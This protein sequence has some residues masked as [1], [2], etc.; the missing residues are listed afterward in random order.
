MDYI[1]E[2]NEIKD[3][4]RLLNVAYEMKEEGYR[5]VQICC[6]TLKESYVLNYS[7]GKEYD[8]LNYK[9]TINIDDEV[10][11]LSS[12]FK[13]AFLYENEMKDLFG[14]KIKHIDVDYK[15]HL[16]DLE[17][18]TPYKIDVSSGKVDEE[19]HE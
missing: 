6:T 7:F 13:P 18:K 19:K 12:I 5:L 9:A 17:K 1:Y 3:L 8:F 2:D 16:Y 4:S 11:S 10:P 14:I 15:G